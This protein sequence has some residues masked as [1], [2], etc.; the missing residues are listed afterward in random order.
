[1]ARDIFHPIVREALEKDGWIITD[2]PY[3]LRVKGRNYEVDLG[4]EQLVA[5]EKGL[6]KIAIEIKS[7]TLPSFPYEFHA[8][9]GQYLNY[10]TFMKIQEPD[11]VL[12]LA[13][14]RSVYEKHFVMD[15]ATQ[16]IVDKFGINLV[17]FDIDNKVIEQWVTR[18]K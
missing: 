6:T 17:I 4:A 16:F 7:F 14:A 3:L 1:M 13:V 2:D 11:R 10:Q 9:L 15:E 18:V 12:Y 8:V 5:A